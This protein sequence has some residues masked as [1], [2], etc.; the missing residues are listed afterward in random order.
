MPIVPG[1]PRDP[2]RGA[3]AVSQSNGSPAAPPS[4]ADLLMARGIQQGIDARRAAN[5]QDTAQRADPSAAGGLTDIHQGRVGGF[6]SDIA[7]SKNLPDPSRYN[8]LVDMEAK[9]QPITPED[10]QFML[11]YEKSQGLIRSGRVEDVTAQVAG[12]ITRRADFSKFERGARPSA[13]VEDFRPGPLNKSEW[14]DRVHRA[15]ARE[16]ELEDLRTEATGE[17]GQRVAGFAQRYRGR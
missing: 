3:S 16:Q 14:E 7:T 12:P 17:Y 6:T 8:K 11:A 9:Q 10:R 2:A 13:L 5:G 1:D 4:M 15:L